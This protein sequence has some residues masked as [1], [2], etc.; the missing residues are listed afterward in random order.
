MRR[1]RSFTLLAATLASTVIMACRGGRAEADDGAMCETRLTY[2]DGD[3]LVTCDSGAKVDC[4]DVCVE[5]SG[6][7]DGLCLTT[8]DVAVC[9][10]TQGTACGIDFT[11]A[12]SGNELALCLGDEVHYSVCVEVCA[13]GGYTDDRGCTLVDGEGVCDCLGFGQMP[14]TTDKD[15]DS[16]CCAAADNGRRECHPPDVCG[17][18]CFATSEPCNEN[19]ECCGWYADAE[20]CTT[21]SQDPDVGLCAPRCSEDSECGGGCCVPTNGGDHVC[22]PPEAPCTHLDGAVYELTRRP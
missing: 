21:F 20:L 9:A 2:C 10:C 16:E 1:S 4:R 19:G 22:A 17:H 18:A 11:P 13:A 7:L 14:C 5:R 15:C 8:A 12:C 3:V 6:Y